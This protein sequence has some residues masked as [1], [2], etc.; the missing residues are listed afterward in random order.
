[1]WTSTAVLTSLK[2]FR[3]QQLC[4]L[5][6]VHQPGIASFVPPNAL[7]NQHVTA[8]VYPLCCPALDHQLACNLQYETQE[9]SK[10]ESSL[11]PFLLVAHFLN[12]CHKLV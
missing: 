9:S 12:N 1:M 3:T 7:A 4:Q 5:T 11:I 10:R 8:C 2:H 6:A